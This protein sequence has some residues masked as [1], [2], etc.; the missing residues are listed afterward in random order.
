M[1]ELQRRKFPFEAFNLSGLRGECL[2][3]PC[4]IGLK[5]RQ[6][7][8]LLADL[9]LSLLETCRKLIDL[10]VLARDKSACV[11]TFLCCRG[12]FRRSLRQGSLKRGNFGAAFAALLGKGAQTAVLR[13]D[14]RGLASEFRH[15]GRMN[16]VEMLGLLLELPFFDREFGAQQVARGEDFLRRKRK[17]H[18]EP[19]R[20]QPYGAPPKRRGGR[21]SDKAR[22][23]KPQR[24]DH[25]LLNHSAAYSI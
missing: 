9:R 3:L 18:F 5:P 13:A 25:C 6:S 11:V 20:G 8:P 22:D 21:K 10:N 15:V 1:L 17:L 24:E 16:A 2:S 19:P 4:H 14:N 23:Q 12:E 7:L